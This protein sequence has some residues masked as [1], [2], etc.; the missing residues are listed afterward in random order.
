MN[1]VS[2][3]SS[4]IYVMD[5]KQTITSSVDFIRSNCKNLIRIL[6]V[7]IAPISTFVGLFSVFTLTDYFTLVLYENSKPHQ[8]ESY[9]W[10]S[11]PV[12]VGLGFA[13]IIATFG[14]IIFITEYCVYTHRNGKD[15]FVLSDLLTVCLKK[16]PNYI[17][18]MIVVLLITVIG[19]GLYYFPAIYLMI[20]SS[21]VYAVKA[22]ENL[23]FGEAIHRC[24]K[25]MK[26]SWW[27]TFGLY[28]VIGIGISILATIFFIPFF[29]TFTVK[30]SY[31]AEQA[32]RIGYNVLMTML[33]IFSSLIAILGNLILSSVTHIVYISLFLP[34][35]DK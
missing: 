8:I 21:T 29:L 33:L 23:S 5:I 3:K 18:M 13:F 7:I 2:T 9:I 14:Q 30:L 1:E 22:N 28:L 24:F 12:L 20:V 15:G 35:R 19:G 10:S 34:C 27:K 17:L 31:S 4:F 26:G 6:T 16:A 32:Q 11:V 25:L